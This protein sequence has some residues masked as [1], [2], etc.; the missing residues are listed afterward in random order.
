MKG[1]EL[2]A[3]AIVPRPSYSL[4]G[5][6]SVCSLIQQCTLIR[7]IKRER[8]YLDI[9]T[10][11]TAAFHLITPTHHPRRRAKRRAAGVCMAFA[12]FEDWLLPNH[13]RSLDLSQFAARVRDHPVPA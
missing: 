13:A 5:G 11:A 8:W 6:L 10:V 9:E 1:M 12:R 4:S 2:A 7:G 3:V